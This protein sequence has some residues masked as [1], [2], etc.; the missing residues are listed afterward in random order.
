MRR[1]VPN[2]KEI[3]TDYLH[4]RGYDGLC[5]GEE[6]GCDVDALMP[7]DSSCDLCR[8]GYRARNEAGEAVIVEGMRG[9]P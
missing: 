8:P 3:V 6:C 5:L 9:K 7:C 1:K 2:V 4:R